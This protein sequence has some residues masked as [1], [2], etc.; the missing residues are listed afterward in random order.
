ML[1]LLSKI[2]LSLASILAIK[3]NAFASQPKEWQLGLQEAATP[4]MEKLTVFHDGLLLWTCIV[5][6]VFVLLLLVIVFVKYRRSVNPVPSK[7]S[8]N[9][10]IEIIW[11]VV[12][13]IILLVIAKPSLEMLNYVKTIPN[14][15]L[16]IKVVGKQ[17]YWDYIYPEHGDIEFS[18]SMKKKEELQNNEP[19][20]LAV[21]NNV[22]VPVGKNIRFLIT[23]GDV[24]HSFAI[25][26]LGVKTDAVP[27]KVNETWANITKP[28]IY[29]G[30]CSELCGSDHGFMPIAIE[31]VTAEQFDQWVEKKKLE[32]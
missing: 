25:P 22:V 21:D 14:P 19:Y 2:I 26:S 8:H 28:G 9:T 7:T 6:S 4:V 5:I 10:L 18:S 13:V 29:Y 1:K 15:D 24:I 20:L 3:S 12:P 31:A 16:T 32:G 30:Q 23:G 11:T 17:W 27:G